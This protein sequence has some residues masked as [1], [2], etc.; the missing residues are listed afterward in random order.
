MRDPNIL[1]VCG[2]GVVVSGFYL[3]RALAKSSKSRHARSDESENNGVEWL[4]VT[5][6]ILATVLLLL[7]GWTAYVL[8]EANRP[9]VWYDNLAEGVKS[10]HRRCRHEMDLASWSCVP[11]L[12]AAMLG[13]VLGIW[14][15]R[16]N[17]FRSSVIDWV[18][19]AFLLLLTFNMFLFIM[20][21]GLSIT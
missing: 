12:N 7:I 15:W 16:R 21:R 14:S 9:W 13:L 5:R 11:S 2:M 19:A 10:D 18:V 1:V 17:G 20:G 4:Q 3:R 8:W 6:R